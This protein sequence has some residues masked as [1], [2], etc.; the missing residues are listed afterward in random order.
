[1]LLDEKLYDYCDRN[2]NRLPFYL[3]QLENET[4]LIAV[5][6]FM[7]CGPVLGRL[8][9]QISLWIKPEQILEIGSFT[10]YSALCLAKG[11]APGGK[12]TC[13][14]INE[15]YKSIIN[16]YFALSGKPEQLNLIIGDA[17]EEI[18][19][20]NGPFD[21]AWI[22]ANKQNNAQLYELILPLMRPGGTVLVDNMLWYGNVLETAPD[23]ETRAILEFNQRIKNDPRI[24]MFLL[25]V[26][27]GLAILQ[28]K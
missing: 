14:E 22:D 8:L 2:S 12:I 25:P 13:I 4:G 1:M 19:K 18:K 7:S 16:K 5:N 20:L 9:I 26:R 28:K 15:E 3:E 27:D 23:K 24:T 21:L 10:G 11:L 6:P 17:L